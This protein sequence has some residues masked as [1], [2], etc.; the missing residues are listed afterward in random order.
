MQQFDTKGEGF[1]GQPGFTVWPSISP[2]GSASTA[3][4]GTELFLSSDA[5]EEASGVPGGTRSNRLL[6]WQLDQHQLPR[7]RPSLTSICPTRS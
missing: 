6:V 7:T 4:G 1:K 3:N 2:Q 5:G